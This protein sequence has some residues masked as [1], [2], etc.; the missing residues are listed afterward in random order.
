ME[1]SKGHLSLEER[2]IIYV[3]QADGA[4]D[5]EIGK[6]IGRDRSVVWREL[7]RNVAPVY[8]RGR[9]SPLEKAKLAHEKAKQRQR[10]SKKGK[11]GALKLVGIRDRVEKLLST[12]YSPEV[13]AYILSNSDLGISISGKTIRRWLTK[14]VPELRKHLPSR[15]KKRKHRLTKRKNKARKGASKKRSIHKRTE[16]INNR[17]SF[18]HYEVDAIVCKQSRFSIISIRERKSRKRW[19]IKVPN[20]KAETVRRV[21]VRFFGAIPPLLRISCT[22]DNGSEFAE[23]DSLEKFLGVIAY[24]C[25]AYCAWQ[26]GAVENQNKEFRYF[27]PKGTDLSKISEQEIKRI[28]TTLNNKP[29]Q[30][31][32][33]LSAEQAWFL[34]C[35]KA[36]CLLH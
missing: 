2:Q 7:K 27:V 6:K 10:D 14:E 12:G 36:Q 8:V 21:L 23:F 3:M 30:C 13:I 28:E 31:L 16:D 19:Y 24:F 20:L 5:S 25:D 32:E 29:M 26:K 35:R 22:Y 15:G 17:K 33:G 4:Q 34:A 9:I 18:G 1:K 11:R